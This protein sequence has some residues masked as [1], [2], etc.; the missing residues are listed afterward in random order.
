MMS[1]VPALIIV[2]PLLAALV[3]NLA[4]WVRHWLCFPAAV[5]AMAA[6]WI[7]SVAV[8]ARVMT[9]GAI[10]YRMA[11]WD[12]PWGISWHIDHL[13]AVILVLITTVALINMVATRSSAAGEFTNRLGTFYA[14]YL[15]FV[16]GLMGIVITGDIFNLYVLLE[17]ASLS[18]YA[19]LGMGGGRAAISSLNYLFMGTI[20]ASLYLFGA[21]YLYIS[22]GSLNMADI[23]AIL[24]TLENVALLKVSFILCLIGLF[25]K[26]ALFPMHTWLP[27]AYSHA[28]GSAASLIAP[29]TTKVMLYVMIRLILSIYQPDFAF[30]R[31]AISSFIVWVAVI[32][33]I[34]GSLL[35]WKQQRLK[36]ML[37][38]IIV[39]EVGYMVGGFWLGN[40]AGMTG[41]VLHIL[42]DAMMTLCLFLAAGAIASRIAGDGFHQLQGLFSKM[43]F[44][45]TAFVV[46]GLSIIGVPPT[47]GFFSK[48]YLLSGG[49]AAG[50][51]GF[52][53]ALI[54]SSL[55]NVVLFFKVIEI[56]Y[57]EPFGHHHH[58]GN[59]PVIEEAPAD[60]VV[61]LIVT[62]GLLIAMGFYAQTL[63][64]LIIEPA[65][66]STI[67]AGL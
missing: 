33:I 21:G 63:V 53:A 65:I 51:Y 20:G 42:N 35:A 2:V 18:G 43:P 8:M 14:L 47:C 59:G 10:I 25:I 29:L 22:T 23:A 38:Y 4:G 17:I 34:A 45:M 39:V 5:C 49:I 55:V 3:V 44:T 19:L 27:N 24:P 6:A 46:A 15:L 61:P 66:S 57:F 64:N 52:V 30:D 12:P 54:I 13:N 62:A 56:A 37:A 28:P 1:Q 7:S 26:M 50:H 48:W 9:E 67:T 40:A 41:A 58:H 16:T 32:A 36:R 31:M 11:G 60:M